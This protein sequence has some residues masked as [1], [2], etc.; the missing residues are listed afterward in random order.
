M[1]PEI[2]YPQPLTPRFIL[3]LPRDPGEPT[4]LVTNYWEEMYLHLEFFCCKGNGEEIP[5]ANSRDRFTNL[6][7]LL[8]L[9]ELIS[10]SYTGN[11]NYL[12]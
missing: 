2:G 1:S 3:G 9:P 10:V 4:R 6:F 12:K 7:L 11:S 8:L 5:G